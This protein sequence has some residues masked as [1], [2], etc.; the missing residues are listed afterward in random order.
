M[1]V[2]L[3]SLFALAISSLA[4]ALGV[5]QARLMNVQ[6]ALMQ[7]QSR[8]S[9]WPY[10]SIG[11]SIKDA[12]DQRGYTWEIN[13]DGVG[14]ARI[15]SVT[16]NVDGKPV[17]SWKDVFRTVFGEASVDATYSQIYGKVL[18][19]NTNRETTIEAVRILDVD[20]AKAFYAAQRR[21]E[22]T[23]CYCSVYEDCW[24]A[25]RQTPKVQSVDRCETEGLIQFEPQM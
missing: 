24:V 21:I 7:R 4:L 3:S 16:V 2:E 9:V 20:Q 25:Y 11:Y 13:N 14:P 1:I 18:P 12:G 22:M 5:Y 8:A 17:S 15:E 10:V 19:A 6:T 23:I